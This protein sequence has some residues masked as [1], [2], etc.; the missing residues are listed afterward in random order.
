MVESSSTAK[1]ADELRRLVAARPTGA[2]LPSARELRSAHAV[3][4]VTVSAAVGMLVREGLLVTEPGRGTF[5]AASAPPPRP[6]TADTGWQTVVLQDRQYDA[7]EPS[8]LLGDPVPGMLPLGGGYLDEELRPAAALARAMSRAARLPGGWDRA[9]LT[10]TPELR[11]ALA[12][13]LG[14]DAAD[15]LV[16][17]GGQAGLSAAVRGLTPPGGTVLVESP[18]YQ[19]LLAVARAAGLRCVPVPT[20]E[21]GLRPDLLDR[22]FAMTGARVLYCQPTYANPTGSVLPADRRADVLAVAAARNAF[23]IE[24]DWARFLSLDENAPPPLLRADADG[25]VVHVSSLTKIA[26]PSLRIGGLVAR[27]PAAGRLRALRTVDDFFVPRPM[28]AAAVD[29]LSGAS[30]PRHLARVRRGL[31]ARRDALLAAVAQD[32]PGCRLQR[33]PLGGLYLWVRLPDGTDDV[34]LAAQ[35]AAAGV[36]LSPGTPYFAG[37]PP[38][39][40]VR[41]SYGGAGEA[42]LRAAVSRLAPLLAP[43]R[44]RRRAPAPSRARGR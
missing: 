28:Q 5:V 23:I 41:L 22:A 11:S 16:V 2:A 36:L 10:G 42:Q 26:A 8:R 6:P 12:T 17:P 4:P 25:H 32:L 33:P 24:D 21:Q 30:W 14:A 15:V 27:G 44:P 13:A 35:A 29:L 34:D 20:D 38:A 43:P 3:S 39:P 19:G 1:L 37:E 31:V 18:T 40:Y 7:S 9:P